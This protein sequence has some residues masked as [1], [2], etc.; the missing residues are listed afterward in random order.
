[1]TYADMPSS[2]HV[3]HGIAKPSTKPCIP[4]DQGDQP[5]L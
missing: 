1:V 4:C 2:H 3:R 5:C